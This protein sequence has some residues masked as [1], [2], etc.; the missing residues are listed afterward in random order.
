[1]KIVLLIED[2]RWLPVNAPMPLNRIGVTRYHLLRISSLALF[3]SVRICLHTTRTAD[4][5]LLVLKHMLA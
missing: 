1:M 4:I 2:L 5:F 3:D